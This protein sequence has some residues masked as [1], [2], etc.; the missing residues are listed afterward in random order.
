MINLSQIPVQ[1][2]GF[3]TVVLCVLMVAAVNTDMRE[4][5]IKNSLVIMIL[6]LGLVAQIALDPIAGLVFWATGLLVG[7]AMFLPFYVGGGMGAGDVKLMAVV[8]AFLGPEAGAFACAT[9]LIA[10]L[11]LA[12]AYMAVRYL[13]MHFHF[14]APITA[15]VHAALSKVGCHGHRSKHGV[16]EKGIPYAASIA[17]GCVAGLWWMGRFEAMI[18]A[19]LP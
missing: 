16:T 18:G 11:P 5:R 1:L 17:V 15:G 8:A 6:L 10:G 13:R 9:A 7:L 3:L 12:I 4:R 14:A 19:L 2:H